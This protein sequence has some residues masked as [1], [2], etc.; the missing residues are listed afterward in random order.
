MMSHDEIKIR[1]DEIHQEIIILTVE[2]ETL[3]KVIRY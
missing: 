3:E 1:I 2:K